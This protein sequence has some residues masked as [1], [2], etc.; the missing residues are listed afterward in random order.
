[1]VVA[2]SVVGDEVVVAWVVDV[3]ERPPI[4]GEVEGEHAAPVTA[5]AATANHGATSLRTSRGYA[6]EIPLP[7][8]TLISVAVGSCAG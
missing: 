4:R 8:C 5:K 3:D 1:M 7:P 2:A 6:Q